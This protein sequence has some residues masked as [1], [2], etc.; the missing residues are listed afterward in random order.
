[1]FRIAVAP[2]CDKRAAAT[3]LGFGERDR[4][5]DPDWNSTYQSRFGIQ[6]M[7]C[8]RRSNL[9]FCERSW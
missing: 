8:S 2:A 5:K 9:D 6:A 3:A 1:M 4:P 7:H